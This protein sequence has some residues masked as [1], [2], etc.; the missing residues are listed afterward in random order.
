M[1]GPSLFVAGMRTLVGY[2]HWHPEMPSLFVAGMRTLVGYDQWHP[3]MPSLFVAGMRT[4]VGYDQW[5]PEMPYFRAKMLNDVAPHP[6][7]L[8]KDERE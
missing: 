2:D 1:P 5:H 4:L 7:R 3:E 8:A 6:S